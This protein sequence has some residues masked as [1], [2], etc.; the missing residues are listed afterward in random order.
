M[1]KH[2]RGWSEEAE[3]DVTAA[4][5]G[6]DSVAH[7]K[8]IADKLREEISCQ[9]PGDPIKQ[10]VW[11][12]GNDYANPGDVHVYLESNKIAKIELK[13]SKDSG[14]G[15]FKNLG[16]ATFTKHIDS[17]ILSYPEHE[18][19]LRNQRYTLVENY[20]NQKFDTASLYEDTVRSI[21]D[22]GDLGSVVDKDIIDQIINITSPGQVNY[23]EYA[24]TE[25]NKHLTK[26]NGYFDVLF[27]HTDT[28]NLRQDIIY[29]VVKNFGNEKFQTIELCD[30]TA[31]NRTVT[32]VISTGKSIK[33]QNAKGRDVLRFSV[34]WKNICQGGAT[35]CFN[36]FVGNEFKNV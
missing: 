26:L 35:P 1:G 17:N 36:V 19:A 2:E 25:L 28:R 27:N 3:I 11:V 33:F 31:M 13:F 6:H 14:E 32:K 10:A 29:C 12:G 20:T 34:H 5:N 8:V 16:A 30:F 15:T 21:R 23:A 18:S 22:R 9:N 4:L 24:A 7:I